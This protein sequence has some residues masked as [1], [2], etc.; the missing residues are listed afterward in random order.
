M[1]LYCFYNID[2]AVQGIIILAFNTSY[3][4]PSGTD[5][6][7]RKIRKCQSWSIPGDN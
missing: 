7:G 1:E 4:S 6:F 2:S 3:S 5:S